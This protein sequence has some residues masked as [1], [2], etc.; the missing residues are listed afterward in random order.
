MQSLPIGAELAEMTVNGAP[1][2][3]Q[4]F[5]ERDRRSVRHPHD[6]RAEHHG[7][8]RARYHVPH[9]AVPIEDGG[10]HYAID[11]DPQGTVIPVSYS[12]LLQ[13]SRRLPRGGAT[14]HWSVNPDLTLLLEST[15]GL[16]L[17]AEVTLAQD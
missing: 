2:D 17:H 7:N 14:D 15:D 6:A 5:V 10:L 1:V 3:A 9:A 13:A 8:R 16:R 4:P 12:V 11:I